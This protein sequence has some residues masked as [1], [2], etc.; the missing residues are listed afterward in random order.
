MIGDAR[1]KAASNSG[2]MPGRTFS[3]ATSR[4]M[5]SSAPVEVIARAAG[6]FRLLDRYF[7]E[8]IEQRS[9]VGA[10]VPALGDL[11]VE[12][13]AVHVCRCDDGGLLGSR[14]LEPIDKKLA[15]AELA[16][17]VGLQLRRVPV[18]RIL[19][20]QRTA[21]ECS[22]ALRGF[23]DVQGKE[24]FPL[25]ARESVENGGVAGASLL[26]GDD[27]VA[28]RQGQPDLGRS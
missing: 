5:R 19:H 12:P 2:A 17:V 26:V 23:V 28:A 1:E 4:I 10:L 18:S 6:A 21:S 8:Q 11:N 3:T 20:R 15:D 9:G 7:L 27:P 14:P 24:R 16:E 25:L 22:L 13:V